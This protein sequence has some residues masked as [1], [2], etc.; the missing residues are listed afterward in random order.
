MSTTINGTTGIDKIQDGTVVDADIASLSASKLSGTVADANIAGMSASKLTG[1]LPAIDG[2][3]LTN[4][5]G[6]GKVLQVIQSTKTGTVTF[7]SASFVDLSFSATITPSS[8]SSKILVMVDGTIYQD[9]NDMTAYTT[10]YRGATNL[11]AAPSGALQG[12]YCNNLA[13]AADAQWAMHMQV[14]DSPNTTSA[15]TY[16]VYGKTDKSNTKLN[17]IRGHASNMILMEIAE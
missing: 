9:T 10:I 13:G 7:S 12:I 11:G 3:S 16:S 15:T 4:L 5:P 14:L 2:S 8:T 6:G 1:S 17:G